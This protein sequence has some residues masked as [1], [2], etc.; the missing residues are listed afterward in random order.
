VKLKNG[1]ELSLSRSRRE[2]LEQKLGVA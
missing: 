2:E 1:I